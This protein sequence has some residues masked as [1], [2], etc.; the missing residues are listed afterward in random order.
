MALF[1]WRRGEPQSA[2]ALANRALRIQL[3]H[4]EHTAAIQTEQQQFLMQE[5]AR[6]EI[7]SWLTVSQADAQHAST[8]YRDLLLGKGLI[9][10]RQ[11]GLRQTLRDDPQWVEL[12]RVSQRLS[13]ATL[14]PPL[15]PSAPQALTAWKT[16]ESGLRQQWQTEKARLELDHERI[17]KALA[18][19]SV[20]FRQGLEQRQVKPEDLIAVL[21]EQTQPT[22]L[23][24]LFEYRYFGRQGEKDEDRIAAFV[25]RADRPVA[26]V[27]LGAAEAIAKQVGQWRDS[28][29]RKEKNQ[30]FGD[31]LRKRVW[32]PLEE[33]LQGI[34]T[35]LIST[36]GV[37]GLLPFEALPGK[38]EGTL[39][40]EV[41]RL[42]F[43]PVPQLIPSLLAL[44]GDAATE[45]QVAER[46]AQFSIL[47]F[48]THGLFEQTEQRVISSGQAFGGARG[49]EMLSSAF[50]NGPQT[51]KV[52]R[53]GLVLAGANRKPEDRAEGAASEV[54]DDGLLM[55]N[56]ILAMPLENASLV[57]MSACDTAQGKQQS[58]E[59]LLGIQRA[60]QVAGART[61]V[62]SLWQV[63]DA[64]TVL[65]MQRFYENLWS[66]K[67][68]RLDSLR[69]AQLWMLRSGK[70]ALRESARRAIARGQET[71]GAKVLLDELD[72]SQDDRLPR[73]YWAAFVL[74]GDWR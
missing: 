28:I 59:G 41:Y 44:R 29:L 72:N 8:V 60:F 62:A 25:A 54:P 10:A 31:E 2:N 16:H 34:E 5:Q 61:T 22:A 57:V 18:T 55:D 7:S 23:I 66:G 1:H 47:H 35:V 70:P 17:E 12:R 4:L 65:L 40:I 45:R 73:Y 14:S 50:D 32:L 56:E 9:T 71:R 30:H 13:T 27:E 69:E 19:K 49:A 39:L 48:A 11:L 74:S 67:L 6:S 37:L 51:V 42:A 38:A 36:D 52:T 21:K 53:S 43:V 58:G 33:H 46:L 3:R 64:A 68:S 24:D 63:D 20:A 26:R 15:P